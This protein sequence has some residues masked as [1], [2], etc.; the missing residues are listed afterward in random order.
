MTITTTTPL[1]PIQPVGWLWN[2]GGGSSIP[3]RCGTITISIHNS[4][5]HGCIVIIIISICIIIIWRI[6][7]TRIR[8]HMWMKQ[9]MIL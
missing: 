9:L 4:T 3:R 6:L 2:G 8:I 1:C 5:V 7:H